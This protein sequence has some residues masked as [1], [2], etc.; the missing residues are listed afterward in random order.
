MKTVHAWHSTKF[1]FWPHCLSLPKCKATW[2]KKEQGT[3]LCAVVTSAD[4]ELLKHG[5]RS[6]PT[7]SQVQVQNSCAAPNGTNQLHW[8]TLK[9]M[10]LPYCLSCGSCWCPTHCGRTSYERFIIQR[11][12]DILSWT[13]A[14]LCHSFHWPGCRREVELFIHCCDACI[15]K[16]GPS[17]QMELGDCCV[18]NVCCLC[19]TYRRL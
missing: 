1:V 4:V 2:N 16:K 10:L 15:A 9:K 14:K 19:K 13:L 5:Q 11:G 17:G 8:G 7:L 18:A 6:D 3:V 12:A